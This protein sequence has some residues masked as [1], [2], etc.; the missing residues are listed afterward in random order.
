MI[1]SKGNIESTPLWLDIQ[2]TIASGPK[3]TKMDVRG[4]VHTTEDDFVVMKVLEIEEECDYL[5]QMGPVMFVT[6]H[7]GM[8]DYAFKLYPYRQNLEFSIKYIPLDERAVED[9]QDPPEAIRY[10]AIFDPRQNPQV[11]A[12]QLAYQT[13]DSLNQASMVKIRL[14]L[15]LRQW[16]PLRTKV[17]HDMTLINVSPEKLVFNLL[18]G[19]SDNVKVD[20][21]NACDG[22]DF[23]PPDNTALIQNVQI[24]TGLKLGLLPSFIQDKVNGLYNAGVGTFFQRYDNKNLWFVYPTFNPSRFDSD[25][26]RVVIYA[27]QSDRYTHVNRTYKKD[28]KI[29]YIA[30]TGQTSY[31]DGAHLNEL[32]QGVG[33]R[34]ADARAMMLKP[35]EI[36]PDGPVAN[37]ARLNTEI[38]FRQRPDGNMYSQTFSSSSNPFELYSELAERALARINIV[39]ENSYPDLIYP[40]MPCKYVFMNQDEYTERKGIIL[41]KYSTTQLDGAPATSSSYHTETTLSILIEPFEDISAKPVQKTAGEF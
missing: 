4:E 8:G 38:A 3:Q 37:R 35:V 24:P 13:Y 25:V 41:G 36:T 12:S 21:K 29:L 16:E 40:G 2:D 39:W 6:F 34:V 27:V 23:V 30:A 11:T 18:K 33:V 15:Q 26:N 7:L 20:G 17:F 10:K 32:N 5:K 1:E 19:E 28:G 22:I 31:M 14:E 9:Y